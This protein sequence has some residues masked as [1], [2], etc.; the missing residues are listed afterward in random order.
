RWR[1]LTRITGALLVA[2]AIAAVILVLVARGNLEG[3]LPPLAG[4]WK[5]E[6]LTA[7]VVI[8]RDERGVPTI[9]GATRADV[10]LGTGFVHGQ[11]RFF[12][13]DLL[14]RRAAGELSE[15]VGPAALPLDRQARIHRFRHRAHRRLLTLSAG[16]R[17]V[18]DAY[19][20]G[21]NAGL[22]SLSNRPFEYHLLRSTPAPRRAEDTL[23]VALGMFPILQGLGGDDERAEG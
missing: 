15:L 22:G 20:R 17:E 13:M 9:R 21:V 5:V 14:R 10:A 1:R 18:L 2:A 8:D 6:G 19:A 23:L 4:T 12:Q 3:S 11:D 16:E 7:E